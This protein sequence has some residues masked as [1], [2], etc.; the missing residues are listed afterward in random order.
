MIPDFFFPPFTTDTPNA[1]QILIARQ[2]GFGRVAML[3]D[4]G[5]ALRRYGD[6]FYFALGTRLV[7]IQ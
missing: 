6:V 7:E 1:A 2:R 5:M 3:P 4:F